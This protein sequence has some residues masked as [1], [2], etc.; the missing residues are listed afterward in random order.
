MV[1]VAQRPLGDEMKPMR[2][3][4]TTSRGMNKIEQL[5][6]QR[7]RH[8]GAAA[9][10]KPMRNRQSAETKFA[11]L[12]RRL[13]EINDLAA[14]GAVL[15][16]DQSTYMPEGGAPARARQGGANAQQACA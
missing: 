1:K 11:E 4:A 7:W 6:G 9:T 12:K 2:S 10:A 15:G 8:K 14:A 13:L 5:Q 3:P 16:W